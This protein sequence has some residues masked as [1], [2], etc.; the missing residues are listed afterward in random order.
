MMTA[1]TRPP[2]YPASEQVELA[3][4]VGGR[5]HAE[6]HRQ[7]DREQHGR[8][9]ELEGRRQSR[10]DQ[11]QGRLAVLQR[12]PEVSMDRP[13][14]EAPV[15]HGQGVGESPLGPELRDLHRGGPRRQHD[16]GRVPGQERQEERDDRD[17]EDNEDGGSQI[18]PTPRS[19][20]RRPMNR[21]I[22]LSRLFQAP[23]RR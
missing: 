1:P 21:I 22:V 19:T 10:R 20:M 14:Q 16:L 11:R 6:R 2:R 5:Q 23:V 3:T 4:A 17:T 12:D 9:G 13:A 7:H 8:H 18:S 15:L